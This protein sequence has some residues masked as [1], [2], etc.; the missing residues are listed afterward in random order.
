MT[1]RLVLGYNITKGG[2]GGPGWQ[3]GRKL[4]VET[5][6]KLSD[7]NLGEN[8]PK[9]GTK[10]SLETRKKKRFASLGNKSNTGK[11][12]STSHK[13]KIGSAQ[14]AA[15]DGYSAKQ[16]LERGKAMS[17]GWARRRERLK[18]GKCKKISQRQ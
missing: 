11:K 5:K 3:K 15:W 16:K 4:S 9:W 2:D 6:K 7:I 8:H 17:L 13:S 1:K 14:Q 12:F 18:K 10:D